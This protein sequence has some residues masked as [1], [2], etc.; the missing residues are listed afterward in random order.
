MCVC[1]CVWCGGVVAARGGGR[2]FR[3]H[4]IS[5]TYIHLDSTWGGNSVTTQPLSVPHRSVSKVML[6]FF[7]LKLIIIMFV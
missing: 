2:G 4:T 1:V 6:K 3:F 5:K 7:D